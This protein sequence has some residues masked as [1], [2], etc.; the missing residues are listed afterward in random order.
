[1]LRVLRDE[2]G[3]LRIVDFAPLVESHR[4]AAVTNQFLAPVRL[5]AAASDRFIPMNRRQP[6]EPGQL[7][8]HEEP[9]PLPRE[10]IVVTTVA[11]PLARHGV[12]DSGRRERQLG[13][14]HGRHGISD[15]GDEP[16][17]L[18]VAA[19]EPAYKG[20]RSLHELALAH[21][22]FAQIAML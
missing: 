11:M 20:P 3:E 8:R 9:F 16:M 22:S 15:A 14:A 7:R 6:K 2:I 19:Q 4:H 10:Q 13:V 21:S 1:M 17:P 5:A 18:V 12:P